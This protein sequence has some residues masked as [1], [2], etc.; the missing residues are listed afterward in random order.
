MKIQKYCLVLTLFVLTNTHSFAQIKAIRPLQIGE[1]LPDIEIKN[2]INYPVEDFKFSDLRGKLLILDF[3]GVHCSS[4]ISEMPKIMALQKAFDSRVQFIL[5]TSDSRSEVNHL[6][7]SSPMFK[8]IDLPSIFGDTILSRMFPYTSYGLHV[9]IDTI[10]KV[11]LKTDGDSYTAND[12]QNFLN[13]E[14]VKLIE[15]AD[16]INFNRN[17]P[18]WLEGNG[19]QLK[20]FEYYS[21]ITK[22]IPGYASCAG[23]L[24]LDS[25]SGKII[26]VHFI[27]MAIGDLFTEAYS[28]WGKIKW[29]KFTLEVRDSSKYLQPSDLS[30]QYE[31]FRANTFSYD[32]KL[33]V[34]RSK[35]V[36]AFMRQDLQRYFGLTGKIEK[37]RQNCWLLRLKNNPQKIKCDSNEL[38]DNQ[39]DLYSISFNNIESNEFTNRLSL[40]VGTPIFDE[41]N[42]KGMIHLSIPASKSFSDLNMALEKYGFE[43]VKASR[44]IN[45]FKLKELI[46]FSSHM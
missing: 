22:N 27:N 10:G 33:P 11:R 23:N 31:W 36:F 35:E 19:R 14:K 44:L 26:G 38:S 15:R 41:T 18:L 39:N 9:W 28:E 24:I 42:Y 32:L 30:G 40:L 17:A 34:S 43:L 45:V 7:Q 4:C 25:I 16:T 8:S 12:I 46:D 29:N 1:V 5:V 6:H 13:G 3:W 20:Y 37:L 2:V 21:L